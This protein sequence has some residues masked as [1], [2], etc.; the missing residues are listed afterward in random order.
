MK[1]L[2]TH[3]F[4]YI[5]N[6]FVDDV[7]TAVK[8]GAFYNAQNL[9]SVSLPAVT[10]V[11]AFAFSGCTNVTIDLTWGSLVSIGREA[12][13]GAHAGIPTS[14]TLS[15]V[16]Q[17]DTGVFAGTSSARNTRLTS[18]SMPKWT[19]SSYTEA[20]LIGGSSRGAFAYCSALASVSM[21]QL[22]SVPSDFFQYCIALTEVS[23]PKGTS[24]G[25][26]AFTN[27][28]AL[29]KLKLGGAVTALSSAFLS[30]TSALEA[31][32]LSGVT[33]VPTLGASVFT[34]TRISSGYAYIYVLASLE[35]SFKLASNWSTY[36]AQIRAIE[37]YPDICNVKGWI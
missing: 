12:F 1:A 13:A 29:R 15:E 7:V 10:V 35:A 31:L 22:I 34:N 19:G 2:L 36:A 8:T 20:G 25:S 21:P 14:L 4:Q 9:S 28:T 23:F 37:D 30:G 17:F 24:I 3:D 27:C 11:K 26:S 33:T 6:T 18:I 16:L 5:G 32:I